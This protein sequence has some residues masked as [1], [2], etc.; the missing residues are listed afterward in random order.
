MTSA[1]MPEPNGEPGGISA[2]ALAVTGFLQQGQSPRCKL[3]RVVTG[4][5]GGSST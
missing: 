1:T 5:M 3:M 4:L 2:G